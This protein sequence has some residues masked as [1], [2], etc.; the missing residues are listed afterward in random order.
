[1]EF[2]TDWRYGDIESSTSLDLKD[3]SFSIYYVPFGDRTGIYCYDPL[4]KFV[5]DINEANL[6]GKTAVSLF[7]KMKKPIH[8]IL[9]A[10]YPRWTKSMADYYSFLFQHAKNPDYIERIRSPRDCPER[11][12]LY[13]R[14]IDLE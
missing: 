5:F 8:K 12:F 4:V 11:Y 3:V 13:H 9:K 14:V 2:C 1:M 6:S 10:T 7:K